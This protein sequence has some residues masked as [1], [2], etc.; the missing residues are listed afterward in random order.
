MNDRRPSKQPVCDRFV[1][2]S[3]LRDE[4]VNRAILCA[5]CGND[6]NAHPIKREPRSAPSSN[7]RLLDN[8]IQAVTL[9]AR[10]SEEFFMSYAHQCAERNRRAEVARDARNAVLALMRAADEP[11]ALPGAENDPL[12][13]WV[14]ERLE[15]CQEIA[16][17]KT[18]ND[19]TGW[20]DD[21]EQFAAI[22]RR[23]CSVSPPRDEYLDKYAPEHV[24]ETCDFLTEVMCNYADR[25]RESGS[26][27]DEARASL[28]GTAVDFL[29]H[30]LQQQPTVTKDAKP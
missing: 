29:S 26:Q 4:E 18:G 9:Q 10:V 3:F 21:A 24:R 6:K 13:V 28:V 11:K 1:K 17:K 12:V 19:R 14:L 22:L 30:W 23:L 2:P 7:E 15:N 25:A 5:S 27:R 16:A 20:L 8:L